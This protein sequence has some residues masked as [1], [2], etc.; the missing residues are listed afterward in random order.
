MPLT[1]GD[2]RVVQLVR[3][4]NA[5]WEGEGL[6]ADGILSEIWIGTRGPHVAIHKPA[7]PVEM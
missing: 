1:P 3:R 2:C 7:M 5:Y 6:I 4:G